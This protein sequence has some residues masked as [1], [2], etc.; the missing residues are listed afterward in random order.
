MKK[1]AEATLEQKV[2]FDPLLK[3]ED[4]ADPC[5]IQNIA[6]M[7]TTE[8][9]SQTDTGK[10]DDEYDPAQRERGGDANEYAESSQPECP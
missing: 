9:H 3:I 8:N 2:D 4:P 1:L 6:I 10:V 7:N 5:S